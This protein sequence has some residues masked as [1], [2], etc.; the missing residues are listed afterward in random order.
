ME[1]LQWTPP[2][3]WTSLACVA[4][5]ACGRASPTADAR[6][7]S[8]PGSTLWSVALDYDGMWAYGIG[9]PWTDGEGDLF[10]ISV[11]GGEITAEKRDASGAVKWASE[12]EPDCSPP[13]R[14]G[15]NGLGATDDGRFA[16]K[17][18]SCPFA[19]AND[20]TAAKVTLLD[21]SGRITSEF[22]TGWGY[23]LTVNRFGETYAISAD[24]GSPIVMSPSEGRLVPAAPMLL[25]LIRPD[26]TDAWVD[27]G[28]SLSFLPNSLRPM[29][30]GGAVALAANGAG[31]FRIDRA[32]RLLWT[33]DLPVTV[34]PYAYPYTAA[35]GDGSFLVAIETSGAV[36]YGAGRAGSPGER[37][38]ALLIVTSDGRPGTVT[39][40]PASSPDSPRTLALTALTNGG[41]A[42]WEFGATCDR[43]LALSSDLSLLW[44]RRLDTSCSSIVGSAVSTREG[45]VLL[46]A[47]RSSATMNLVSLQQ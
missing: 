31:A 46:V 38:R 16:V 13:T 4:L 36:E 26:G 7:P 18:T 21:R 9:G 8:G 37:G 5:L 45:L 6:N 15:F 11:N 35:L 1:S 43:L 20:P 3:R 23:A 34:T 29:P 47:S 28:G 40:L 42:A 24:V 12:V 32:G 14:W 19:Y 41:A 44:Q 30:D 27:R 25:R 2:L 33:A 10:T 39:S 17:V 22:T